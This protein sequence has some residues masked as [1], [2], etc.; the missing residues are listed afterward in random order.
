M[1]GPV[2]SLQNRLEHHLLNLI[3]WGDFKKVLG[4]RG[5]TQVVPEICNSSPASTRD[6]ELQNCQAILAMSGHFS[7]PIGATFRSLADSL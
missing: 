6:I 7:S 2:N 3:F 1:L 4:K 5:H